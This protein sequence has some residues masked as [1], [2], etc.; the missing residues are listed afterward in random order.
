M[1][2]GFSLVL[3]DSGATGHNNA[4][5]NDHW[6]PRIE[7]RTSYGMQ[8]YLIPWQSQ[9]TWIERGFIDK[10]LDGVVTNTLHT[11]ESC[12]TR[13]MHVSL[14]YDGTE[15]LRVTLSREGD[16]TWAS[17]NALAGADFAER[18][19]NGA[20]LGIWGK[21]G[22][23]FTRM[24][25][26]NLCL[27]N[28]PLGTGHPSHLTAGPLELKGGKVALGAE[29]KIESVFSAPLKI[30]GP[31]EIVKSEKDQFTLTFASPDWTFDLSNPAAG[32]SLSGAGFRFGE[33]P[34]VI[35]LLGEVAPKSRVLAD[36]TGLKDAPAP[37]FMLSEETPKGCELTYRD[38]LLIIKRS[39]GTCIQ[40]L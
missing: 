14:A 12:K 40:L 1:G 18:F 30:S 20:Y 29:G 22:G 3:H 39:I 4:F 2:D 19:P 9:F 7:D 26:S 37:T 28:A 10:R 21:C 13:P 17:T 38:G 6:D 36:L 8:F 11:M 33:A 24:K 23:Y 35:H 5:A 25:L 27:R 15:A 34:I 31:A 32:L 16:P